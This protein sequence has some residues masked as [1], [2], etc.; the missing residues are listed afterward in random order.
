MANMKRR[1][2]SMAER[3]PLCNKEGENIS[4][5][6]FRCEF[7]QVIWRYFLVSARMNI[8]QSNLGCQFRSVLESERGVDIN[9]TAGQAFLKGL[10]HAVV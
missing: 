3:C 8:D 5:L 10:S 6:F 4:H 2:Y 7:A 1:G 9:G